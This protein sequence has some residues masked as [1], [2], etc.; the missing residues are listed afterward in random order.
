MRSA[1]S[2]RSLRGMLAGPVLLLG[3]AFIMVSTSSSEIWAMMSS[4]WFLFF[5]YF[6]GEALG[7]LGTFFSVSG[8]T[9]TKKLFN[10]PA[11][12]AGSSTILPFTLSWEIENLTLFLTLTSFLS[13]SQ[14]FLISD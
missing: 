9:F 7:T 5:K 4:N 12:S 2:L 10:F 3:K 6:S 1:T 13:P 8:P 11:I 14:V